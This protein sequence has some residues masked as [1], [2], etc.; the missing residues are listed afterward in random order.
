MWRVG[1]EG[2]GEGRV[3]SARTTKT[4]RRVPGL[5]PF[6]SSRPAHPKSRRGTTTRRKAISPGNVTAA[7]MPRGYPGLIPCSLLLFARSRSPAPPALQTLTLLEQPVYGA[8]DLLGLPFGHVG[9]DHGGADLG[10]PEELLD[11][12]EV[13]ASLEQMSGKGVPEHVRRN[14]L[15]DPGSAGGPGDLQLDGPRCDVPV[16]AMA[17][18]EEPI[19]GSLDP[20]VFPKDG[21][22]DGRQHHIPILPPFSLADMD[23][24]PPR[25]DVPDLQP[26]GLADPE[27]TGI[28]DIGDG[29]VLRASEGGEEVPDLGFRKDLRKSLLSLGTGDPRHGSRAIQN[30]PVEESQGAEGLVHVA[31]RPAVSEQPKE[32]V[33]NLFGAGGKVGPTIGTGFIG[34]CW[35][36]IWRV[37]VSA[38]A[39]AFIESPDLGHIDPAGLPGEST[40]HHLLVHPIQEIREPGEG[41][42]SGPVLHNRSSPIHG[43]GA[44][45]EGAENR[46]WG[47][48]NPFHRSGHIL[49]EDDGPVGRTGAGPREEL[50]NPG[51]GGVWHVR[52]GSPL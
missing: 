47:R 14:A 9:V 20:R 51:C 24:A 35:E 19:V 26:G 44:M 18:W 21:Q 4:G 11:V 33:P 50:V 37:V 25:I 3:G 8:G 23:L 42:G 17:R 36:P 12:P 1:A 48:T 5:E 31:V 45:P 22:H 6:K 52:A 29:S 7:F 39:P 15:F 43:G 13:G 49:G 30:G 40:E 34:L 28:K 32:P 27:P 38:V 16:S 10:V 41:V 46:T 2:V